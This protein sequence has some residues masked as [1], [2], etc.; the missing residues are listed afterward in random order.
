MK[1]IFAQNTVK[2]TYP[3][4]HTW[5][6]SEME[7]I[8]T[9]Q[10]K[11][12]D[13]VMY[14]NGSKIRDEIIFS[15]IDVLVRR[16]NPQISDEEMDQVCNEL[17]AVWVRYKGFYEPL[18]L[19]YLNFLMHVSTALGHWGMLCITFKSFWVVA[20]CIGKHVNQEHTV[21]S[22]FE[23]VS[24]EGV[25]RE[26]VEAVLETMVSLKGLTK[27][28]DK[29]FASQINYVDA[30]G[31]DL[32]FFIEVSASDYLK[33]IVEAISL[34][35]VLDDHYVSAHISEYEV[36]KR[37]ALLRPFFPFKNLFYIFR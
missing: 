5:L 2:L 20:G 18:R 23:K 10:L 22:I 1:K 32:D 34:K 12:M 4:T 25:T 13:G 15:G 24:G 21:D 9:R 28:G 17:A 33:K 16:E 37:S 36:K 35:L 30:K 7:H 14:D 31:D 27:N 26:E 6:Q 8:H 3:L 29:Y 11:N 19:I